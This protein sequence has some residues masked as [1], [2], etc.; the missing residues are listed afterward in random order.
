MMALMAA[1]T[2]AQPIPTPFLRPS[3]KAVIPKPR[4][5]STAPNELK[6]SSVLEKLKKREALALVFTGA[7]AALVVS[8]SYILYTGSLDTQTD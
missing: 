2:S 7:P 5:P 1:K 3:S 8:I 4:A 6:K